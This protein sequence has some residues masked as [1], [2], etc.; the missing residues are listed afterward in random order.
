[1]RILKLS[2]KLFQ[3]WVLKLSSELFQ[4]DRF[5]VMHRCENCKNERIEIRWS[6]DFKYD[7]KSNCKT[8]DRVIDRIFEEC[9]VLNVTLHEMKHRCEIW[10]LKLTRKYIVKQVSCVWVVRYWRECKSHHDLIASLC[11]RILRYFLRHQWSNI[12]AIWL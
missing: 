6:I 4:R 8:C 1:M 7:V 3:R 10:Y 9:N 11:L 2:C 5:W 12:Y